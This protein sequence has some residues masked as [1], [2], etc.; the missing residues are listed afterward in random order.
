M[1]DRSASFRVALVTLILL[2]SPAVLLA[3]S[4]PDG[5]VD[6]ILQ[7]ASGLVLDE[8]ETSV[9]LLGTPTLP[10]VEV[11]LN[12][13]ATAKFLVDLGANVVIV[14]EDVFER[15]D[16]TV[17]FAREPRDVGQFASFRIGA[18][19]YHDVTVGV[20]PE[21]DVDG[22][23]GYNMLRYSSFTL[24]YPGRRFSLHRRTLPAPAGESDV[25]A[26][27]AADNL[28]MIEVTLNEEP[29]MVNLDTGA[30][31]WM[32][33][34]PGLAERLAWS[35]KPA[36]GP[37]MSNN[38]TGDVTVLQGHGRGALVLGPLAIDTPLIYV[39]EDAE[40][41]WLGSSAMNPAA[42]TFDPANLRLLIEMAGES[43]H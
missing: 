11:T 41:A 33:V 26:Y 23:I 10:L 24:D 9:P 36:P 31:E 21:L 42:W 16:G 19:E 6:Q 12:G 35:A 20:W 2:A 40:Y 14:R 18:A 29:I 25:L 22:V 7:G 43:D 38:Q 1:A 15:G 5:I 4:L 30:S 37:T 13:S 32:T 17:L 27:S 28:P 34:P 3:R 8:E 39:N